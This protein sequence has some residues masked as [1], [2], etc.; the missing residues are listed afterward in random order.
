MRDFSFLKRE[1]NTYF[2][3]GELM[4]IYLPKDY[5]KQNIAEYYGD[6]IST[7]GVF[8]FMTFP[9]SNPDRKSN[10]LRVMKLPMEIKFEFFNSY[11]EELVLESGM[12]SKKYIIFQLNKGQMFIDS[13]LKEQSAENS[14]KFIYLLHGGNLPKSLK[15]K[16][17]I[18]L[19]HESIR[20]NKVNLNNPSS[21]F[22]TIIAELCR[23][24]NNIELP[25]RINA[26]KKDDINEYGYNN[27]NLTKLPSINSTF[28]AMTFED[29]N[30]SIIS[31]VKKTRNN[32]KEGESPVEKIIKY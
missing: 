25:F 3:D 28:N 22:E 18:N 30:Q 6:K 16:D 27:I 5:F 13:V 10:D 17:I 15:Y 4:E 23:D 7:L 19:Y 21:M 20:L 32:E 1:E 12:E 31:S 29:I 24:S 9:T 14:K 11:E 8:N 26:G 2:F